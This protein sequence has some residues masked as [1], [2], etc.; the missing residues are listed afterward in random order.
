MFRQNI[1]LID[2]N[3][4][5]FLRNFWK[6]FSACLVKRAL[7]NREFFLIQVLQFTKGL[8]NVLARSIF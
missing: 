3:M 1:L 6:L 2:T 8:Q 7:Y 5:E 4:F